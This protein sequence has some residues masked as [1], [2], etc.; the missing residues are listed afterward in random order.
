MKIAIIN[1][2]MNKP[3]TN[4]QE[5]LKRTCSEMCSYASQL[6]WTDELPPNSRTHKESMYGFKAHAFQY[7]FDLGY[8]VVLWLDSPTVIKKDIQFIFDKINED[9]YF[10]TETH[11]KLF[12][13]CNDRTLA[14]FGISRD[15]VKAK[16]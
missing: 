16:G 4:Y 11:T 6:F 1:V 9:G 7:A 2:S 3:Y 5:R 14:Y 12:Q 13:Y 8:D 10:A 15:E